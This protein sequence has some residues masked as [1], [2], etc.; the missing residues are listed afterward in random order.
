M[1]PAQNIQDQTTHATTEQQQNTQQQQTSAQQQQQTTAQQQASSNLGSFLNDFLSNNSSTGTTSL[2]PF[3][4]PVAQQYFQDILKNYQSG[5]LLPQAYTGERVA[6]LT[7][8]Q[9]LAQNMAK[10]YAT[11]VG[12]DLSS[13]ALVANKLLLDPDYILNPANIPGLSQAKAAN[14]TS[15]THIVTGKQIGRAHV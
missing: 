10:N 1:K 15:M 8:D 7:P 14:T 5:S 4:Q 3:Q 11:G 9:I 6:T 12:G 2:S 13:S